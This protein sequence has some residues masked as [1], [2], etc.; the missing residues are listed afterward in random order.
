MST[1]DRDIDVV[2][3]FCEEFQSKYLD[4]MD[5]AAS[6]LM[7][8]ANQIHGEMRGTK[9]ATKSSEEVI[10]MAKKLQQAVYTG[11]AKILEL[12]KKMMRDRDRGDE[13]TR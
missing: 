1:V 13:F 3:D 11:E 12:K 7:V 2:I 4:E 5:K 9:F 10:L 6:N 8:V